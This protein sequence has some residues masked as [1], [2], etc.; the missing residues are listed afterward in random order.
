ML[1]EKRVRVHGKQDD[2]LEKKRSGSARLVQDSASSAVPS[3]DREEASVECDPLSK[4]TDSGIFGCGMDGHCVESEESELGGFCV[5][6]NLAPSINKSINR[7]LQENVTCVEGPDEDNLTC[8]CSQ[9]NETSEVGLFT[10]SGP[11][12][13][14][15]VCGTGDNS[16][17]YTDDGWRME[18]CVTDLSTTLMGIESYCLSYSHDGS[19]LQCE[20]KANGVVCNSCE[21]ET[22][23]CSYSS[24]SNVFDCTN[25]VLNISGN[26]CNGSAVESFLEATATSSGS[27]HAAKA[28]IVVSAVAA[29]WIASL[30]S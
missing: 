15:T 4:V 28:I 30:G 19:S 5:P 22:V 24:V 26:T 14:G 29:A 10:C 8:D 23:K 11:F 9:F 1:L 16:Y 12:C 17:L 25:T 27:S 20:I 21:M 7:A 13:I 3:H 6:A 18:S 2:V